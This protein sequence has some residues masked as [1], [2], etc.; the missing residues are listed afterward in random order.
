MFRSQDNRHSSSLPSVLVVEDD[1]EILK[2]IRWALAEEYRLVTASERATALAIFKK[3][4]VSVVLLDLGLPP[5]PRDPRE[6]CATMKQ[7][8]EFGY[9]LY[10]KVLQTN[11]IRFLGKQTIEGHECFEYQA[12]FP[13]KKYADQ[14]T[15]VPEDQGSY[16][17]RPLV[18]TMF[19][20]DI[21]LGAKDHLPYRVI[22]EDYTAIYNYADFDKLP[23]PDIGR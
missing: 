9:V 14:M 2:Q 12:Y 6:G 3:E 5:S 15:T 19:H 22:G 16:S 1:V 20:E 11:N 23:A 10:S 18:D 21:C 13:G 17:F 8:A 7:G 4:P